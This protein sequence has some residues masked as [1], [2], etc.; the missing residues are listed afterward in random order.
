MRNA[1]IELDVIA[2][3]G[4]PDWI[5]KIKRAPAVSGA[6][7]PTCQTPQLL[8]ESRSLL[9]YHSEA[10]SYPLQPAMLL[11]MDL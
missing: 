3:G 4:G 1:K 9:E 5:L 10:L 11:V 8:S 6:P 2:T 7:T